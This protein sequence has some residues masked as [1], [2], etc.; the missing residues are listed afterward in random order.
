MMHC[1]Y[2]SVGVQVQTERINEH[3]RL[4]RGNVADR[5]MTHD[6]LLQMNSKRYYIVSALI[7]LEAKIKLDHFWTNTEY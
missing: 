1:E 3:C 5:R 6:W 7:F 4:G 2:I